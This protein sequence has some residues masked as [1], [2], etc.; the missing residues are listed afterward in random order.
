MW[1]CVGCSQLSVTAPFPPFPC[2]TMEPRFIVGIVGIGQILPNDLT[3][4]QDGRLIFGGPLP[5]SQG[6]GGSSWKKHPSPSWPA[7]EL[8]QGAGRKNPLWILPL[9]FPTSLLRYKEEL[10]KL[11][12]KKVLFWKFYSIDKQPQIKSNHQ[13][14]CSSACLLVA[15]GAAALLGC[16][17]AQGSARAFFTLKHIRVLCHSAQATSYCHCKTCRLKRNQYDQSCIWP[18]CCTILPFSIL[19]I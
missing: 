17:C 10:A 13:T 2:W 9:Y 15:P 16:C 18:V 3:R 1:N 6:P 8:E 4:C 19:Q 7:E 5:F 14:S 11:K 12:I